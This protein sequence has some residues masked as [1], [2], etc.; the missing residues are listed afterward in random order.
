MRGRVGSLRPAHALRLHEISHFAPYCDRLMKVNVPVK[1][2]FQIIFKPHYYIILRSL[3]LY[4]LSNNDDTIEST[5]HAKI[6]FK[7]I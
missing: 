6:C 4:C 1:L 5:P 3:A 2:Y 7:S